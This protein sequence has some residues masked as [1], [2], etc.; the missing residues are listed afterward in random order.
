[1][2]PAFTK[3]GDQLH[4]IAV[5]VRPNAEV[6]KSHCAVA[7]I[8]RETHFL[9]ENDE[10]VKF[11]SQKRSIESHNDL[12]T[13]PKKSKHDSAAADNCDVEVACSRE[14]YVAY[15]LKNSL[16]GDIYQLKLLML[17]LKRGLDLKYAF[18]LATEWEEAEKFDDIVFEFHESG[19]IHYRFFQA[20]HKANSQAKTISIRDLFNETN[21]DFSLQKYFTSYRKIK[22][23]ERFK[24]PS[25]VLLDFIICTN[26]GFNFADV[27]GNF[28]L[29]RNLFDEEIDDGI[30]KGPVLSFKG[31][32]SGRQQIVSKLKRSTDLF[33]LAQALLD[34]I[35]FDCNLGDQNKHAKKLNILN[36]YRFPL[37]RNVIDMS[38][39]KL[40]DNFIIGTNLGPKV[41]SLRQAFQEITDDVKSGL[42]LDPNPILTDVE[43]FAQKMAKKINLNPKKD[44]V[45]LNR[46]TFGKNLDKLS[47]YVLVD[48]GDKTQVKFSDAFICC[49]NLPGN[50]DTFS[51]YLKKYLKTSFSSIKQLKFRIFKFKIYHEIY[52][53]D[54][55]FQQKMREKLSLGDEFGEKSLAQPRKLGRTFAKI[56][57]LPSTSSNV[58]TS[59]KP[60]L[61][62]SEMKFRKLSST[63]KPHYNLPDDNLQTIENDIDEFLAKLKFAVNQP[64]ETELSIILKQ[65]IGDSIDLNLKDNDF[66]LSDI[67]TTILD[68]MKSRESYFMTH[69]IGQE[70]FDVVRRKISSL[71]LIGPTIDY[72]NKMADFDIQFNADALLNLNSFLASDDKILIYVNHHDTTLSALKL[73]QILTRNKQPD[74]SYICL[75]MRTLTNIDIRAVMAFNSET[76]NVLVINCENTAGICDVSLLLKL[77]EI[78]HKNSNKK[79]IVMVNNADSLAVKILE[80][81]SSCLLK[82]VDSFNNLVDLDLESQSKILQ[83]V[84]YF[85]NFRLNMSHIIWN[86]Q[87]KLLID[88]NVLLNYIY[89]N[90]IAIGKN[91]KDLSDTKDYYIDRTF[92]RQVTIKS[93]VFKNSTDVF[94][95]ANIDENVLSQFGLFRQDIQRY[96]NGILQFN[97]FTQFVI[98]D[99][100]AEVDKYF[101]LLCHNEH[102]L[103]HN[104][105]L[106]INNSDLLQWLKSSGSIASIRSYID[107]KVTQQCQPN[108]IGDIAENVVII[109]AEPGMGKTTVLTYLAQQ[110]K[111]LNPIDW[112]ARI[113]LN[114]CTT[115]LHQINIE[116]K[117][118]VIGFLRSALQL[119]T[120]F[121]QDLFNCYFSFPNRVAVLFDGY[122]EIIPLYKDKVIAILKLLNDDQHFLWVTTRPHMRYQLEDNLNT[123]SH[124]LAPFT[125][126]DQE[127]FLTKYWHK[128]SQHVNRLNSFIEKLLQL[129][130]KSIRDEDLQF[131]G[132]PLQTKMIAEIFERDLEAF[133]QAVSEDEFKLPEKLDL[134]Q[135]YD[136]FILTKFDIYWVGK[137][138]VDTTSAYESN[139][140]DNFYSSVFV[141][142]HELASLYALFSKV[143]SDKLLNRSQIAQVNNFVKKVDDG[144]EKTGIINQVC[145]GRPEF[146]HRTFAEYFAAKFFSDNFNNMKINQFLKQILFEDIGKVIRRFLDRFF[147]TSSSDVNCY[148]IHM[149]TLNNDVD[150][151][152]KILQTSSVDVTE[153]DIAGRTALH[154]AAA[155][156]YKSIVELLVKFSS[157]SLEFI[158]QKDELFNWSAIAYADNEERWEVVEQLLTM[159][160]D[161]TDLCRALNISETVD[162]RYKEGSLLH[163]TANYNYQRLAKIIIDA[164]KELVNMRSKS[165][166]NRTPLHIAVK[167]GHFEIVKLLVK[168]KADVLAVDDDGGSPLHE[169]ASNGHL[170]VLKVLLDGSNIDKVD[171]KDNFGR[172]PFYNAA[173]NNQ[174]EVAKWLLSRQANIN[175]NEAVAAVG[176]A[177]NWTPL[178]IAAYNGHKEM[179]EFLIVNGSE[180]DATDTIGRTALDMAINYG[181]FEIAALSAPTER[182]ILKAATAAGKFDIIEEIFKNKN[183]DEKIA[184]MHTVIKGW[185]PLH[186]ASRRGHLKIFEYFV[187][188]GADIN[189]PSDDGST[190]LHM[191]CRCGN[192]DLVKYLIDHKVDLMVVDQEDYSPLHSAAEHGH[193]QVMKMIVDE[194]GDEA[195]VNL[196]DKNGTT[197]LFTAVFHDHIDVVEYL[198]SKNVDVNK[199]D[200]YGG[201]PL[202]AAAFNNC[203]EILKRLLNV[204]DVI[205]E[206]DKTKLLGMVGMSVLHGVVSYDAV[207]WLKLFVE[208]Y[209][210]D[211][212]SGHGIGG[213][214]LHMATF[215]DSFQCI[216]YLIERGAEQNVGI[217]IDGIVNSCNMIKENLNGSFGP[218]SIDKFISFFSLMNTVSR[219]TPKLI[220]RGLGYN[221]PL[222]CNVN[223]QSEDEYNDEPWIGINEP[224]VK[225]QL[226]ILKAYIERRKLGD[227]E[228]P[229]ERNFLLLGIDTPKP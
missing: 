193:T 91:L 27:K 90:Q 29:E 177:L 169:A 21:G 118:T 82:K 25:K 20:K 196:A 106:L 214:P 10:S 44:V 186:M 113:N 229:L 157:D 110:T 168:N 199:S 155:Y 227:L 43:L 87:L 80:S 126:S 4:A 56:V 133:C 48:A 115:Q 109:A 166:Y 191:A 131:M 205:I 222:L 31:S 228:P 183:D 51:Q 119:E 84:V 9:N 154:L 78:C 141:I 145:N 175:N 36:I 210:L 97:R 197:I 49:R 30:L 52:V 195:D 64:S 34:C 209:G 59:S 173:Q 120:K 86:D 98:I 15:G 176:Q 57:N 128:Y 26:I 188:N 190:S 226:T 3:L 218:K 121:E 198:L 122:D 123:V 189:L 72:C 8:N 114:E 156:G 153:P 194:L 23:N 137:R 206:L 33:K 63:R 6:E 75:S 37:V 104:I 95:I 28:S 200:K 46:K 111:T 139:I 160:A 181:H 180:K 219:I 38:T 117:E 39:K 12:S 221:N 203:Q 129:I 18:R 140:K 220:S 147:A 132:V 94:M 159:G 5:D 69:E 174:I 77:T 201:T 202:F 152:E 42:N 212:N 71:I 102:Y 32:F 148:Q 89:K 2:I 13:N 151:I 74:G 215:F 17:F 150:Q 22:C 70:I 167:C 149:L 76:T 68:W 50:L 179:V 65:E 224:Y 67:Q 88:S 213:T 96:S 172:S 146:V 216:Q 116:N 158:N 124:V 54:C 171:V 170:D 81:A 136:K 103:G 35:L 223:K 108:A 130:A 24:G 107:L 7:A 1:M 58:A 16:H 47:G 178:H 143:K 61:T 165:F 99:S 182:H 125:K 138:T 105:H 161:E 19:L 127:T 211:V 79:I 134:C 135:L 208:H 217:S 11:S 100:N 92:N 162:K 144:L 14:N 62:N 204:K 53:D 40:N 163:L 101:E 55:Y 184:M 73:H 192:I 45:I 207:D 66:P 85:Q 83:L 112:I 187:N 225:S 93:E 60:Q 142:E 164:N 185:S 41:S